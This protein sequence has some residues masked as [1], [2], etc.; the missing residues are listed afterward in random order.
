M[1]L[2]KSKKEKSHLLKLPRELRDM[3]YQCTLPQQSGVIIVDVQ[4]PDPLK[5]IEALSALSRTCQQLQSECGD[6]FSALA[7]EVQVDALLL[8]DLKITWLVSK[9][10]KCLF[11]PEFSDGHWGW[12]VYCSSLSLQDFKIPEVAI[13]TL[14]WA[15]KK[16]NLGFIDCLDQRILEQVLFSLS[17]SGVL[18][19]P[20]KYAPDVKVVADTKTAKGEPV[21]LIFTMKP[22]TMALRKEADREVM[23]QSTDLKEFVMNLRRG[24]A[25]IRAFDVFID[26]GEQERPWKVTGACNGLIS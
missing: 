23:E 14:P 2:K 9:F 1:P 5:Q 10:L 7:L 11:A 21:H 22:Q 24:M 18:T 13:N 3:I 8:H 4:R 6:L 17:E 15:C 19:V 12:E 16:V 25:S 26:R 20:M